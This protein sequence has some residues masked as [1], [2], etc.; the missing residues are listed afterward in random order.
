MNKYRIYID[1]VGNHDLR[2]ADNPN[3]RFLG[4]SRV[5][6]ELAYVKDVLSPEIENLKTRFFAQHP[7][8]PVILHRK[9]ILH[10]HFPFQ[11]LKNE[12]IRAEFDEQFLNLLNK[13]Q[14]TVIS[15]V[16]DKLEHR[17]RYKTWRY[18]PY[19]YCL[20]VLLE[21]FLFFLNTMNAFGDA[22]AESRGGKEDLKLKDSYKRIYEHG[23]EF[24][25]ADAFQP[26]FTSKEL[27]I[28]PKSAN[29]AGLQ[30][31]DLIAH[32]CRQQI[33]I[34]N[35]LIE[36]ELGNFAGKIMEILEPKFYRHKMRGVIGFGRK[37]LP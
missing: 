33:L 1:E 31:A 9:E 18:H 36:T 4:L 14:F 10:A 7:D 37:L 32:P 19:H 28:R 22:M 30:V 24:Q 16:I 8:E 12:N 26:R 17:E 25:K 29:V 5:I 27:K 3:E 35:N 2:N 34:E 21:R 23:T 11:S 15:V 13:W 6:F 20:A